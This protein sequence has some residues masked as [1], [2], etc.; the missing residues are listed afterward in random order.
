[1]EEG[2]YIYCIIESK[3]PRH[4]DATGI[5]G[6]GDDVYTVFFQD[7]GAVVSKSPVKAWQLPSA[8]RYWP[9]PL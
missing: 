7:I 3:E 6:R 1:M 5:G 2:I 9:S 4:F 8:A